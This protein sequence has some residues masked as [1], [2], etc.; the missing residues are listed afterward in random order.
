MRP[1]VITSKLI[2]NRNLFYI[3][4]SDHVISHLKS[5]QLY[6]YQNWT[7]LDE[8][9]IE[10]DRDAYVL[11]CGAHIGTFSFIAAMFYNRKIIM[12]DGA[13]K[14]AECLKKTFA[15][16]SNV[17]V[18]HKILLDKERTCSFNSDYGPYGSA[19]INESGQQISSTI[20]AIVQ[21]RKVSGIKLDIEGNETDAIVGATQTICSNKPPI[22]MEVNGH[23]LR[24]KNK[25]PKHIFDILDNLDYKYFILNNQNLVSINKNDIFPF[26]VIDII[27]IHQDNIKFYNHKYNIVEP[28]N[29]AELRKIAKNNYQTS[30]QDCKDYFNTL[31]VNLE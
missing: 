31:N 13:E 7:I 26:C 9:I 8:F 10:N 23:C 2:N 15:E 19:A 6:G 11:D 14:N 16:N 1:F 25:R 28:M 12:I 30:N 29:S 5:G 4:S 3:D 17:E 18:H 20:D 27:A 24:L 22:L 21:H